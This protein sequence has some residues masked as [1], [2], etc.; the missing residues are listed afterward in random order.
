[1]ITMTIDGKEIEIEDGATI[2]EAAQKAGANVST[3]CYDKRLN[4]FGACRICLV[5]LEG[6]RTKFTPSCTTPATNGM[7][8]RTTSD[9]L[10]KARKTI[11]EL[12]LINHPLDCPVCDK[13]GECKLQ[14]LVYEYG[15]SKNRFEGEKSD[16]PI[17]Y[18]SHLIERNLNRC[19]LCGKCAR[20][21]DEIQDVAEVSFV[22][23]GIKAKIGTDFDRVLDCEFCGQC[24]DICPVGAL[25]SKLFKFNARV[26][27]LTN[28][29]IICPYCNVGCS[30]TARSRDGR[31][32]KIDAKETGVNEGGVCAKGHFG[33]DYIYAEDRLTQPLIKK[34]GKLI[35]SDWDEAFNLIVSKFS[36]LKGE[37]GLLV[38]PRLTNEE[39]SAAKGLEH[40]NIAC[41]EDL[42]YLSALSETGLSLGEMAD[43][44]NSDCILL[45]SDLSSENPVASTFVNYAVKRQEANLIV[46]SPRRIKASR[47]TSNQLLVTPGQEITVINGI[48]A[49][50]FRQNWQNADLIAEG[51]EPLKDHLAKYTI[52]MT[53]ERSGVNR[54]AL[55][56]ATRIY[57]ESKNPCIILSSPTPDLVRAASSLLLLKGKTKL[58]L[59]GKRSNEQGAFEV[60]GDRD[61]SFISSAKG[62][63]L[64]GCELPAEALQNKEFIVVS[65]LYLTETAKIADVVLPAA[66]GLEK[67][68]TF[69]NFEGKIQQTDM[70]SPPPRDAKSDLEI[71]TEI[72]K[73]IAGKSPISD[74]PKETREKRV[75]VIPASAKPIEKSEDYPFY[76]LTEPTRFH[77]G[78]TSA[79]SKSL[80]ELCPSPLL[81]MNKAD[82]ERL[83]LCED[84]QITTP[85]GSL[86]VQ[87]KI[88]SGLPPKV[89]LLKSHPQMKIKLEPISPANLQPTLIQR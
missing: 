61:R 56:A 26:W 36:K 20:I 71:I 38:S 60:L 29:D 27:E 17:D 25:T 35:P 13:A 16:L 85:K 1:M 4:P 89:A 33:F 15:V 32:L 46:I 7:V 10:I 53:E 69:T 55:L 48:M 81:L 6:S 51:F 74:I 21:C 9:A 5:E 2:L 24:I 68:G 58:H 80:M 18:R 67:K 39:I 84:V 22:N 73:R 30:L 52:D 54:E 79:F 12:L 28:T 43:I 64:M 66:A 44:K 3:L 83:G 31:I 59:L 72:A 78:R 23:R 37:M 88:D 70:S 11:L 41:A 34:D 40:K 45:F 77:S 76:L 57:A 62:L 42:K 50:M 86:T 49:E 82:K 19:I 87:C 65:D 75:K 63:F 14:D 47:L 8:V